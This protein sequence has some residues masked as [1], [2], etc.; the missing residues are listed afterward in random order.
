MAQ[1]VAMSN[2]PPEDQP[3]NP[4]LMPAPDGIAARDL[5]SREADDPIHVG[6]ALLNA[7]HATGGPDRA[8]L[9]TLIT[10]ES[11]DW[12]GDFRAAAALVSDCGMS[13]KADPSMDSDRVSYVKYIRD[14]GQNYRATG[15]VM[16][17]IR[18]VAT[19]VWRPD[20]GGWRAHHL[21][22]YVHPRDLPL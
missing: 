20:L 15:D 2:L 6:V 22:D 7:L 19:L 4:G 21:G 14:D 5:A 9:A 3:P 1:W 11:R 16:L 8:T 18:A 13:S 10:P 12:W 17:M